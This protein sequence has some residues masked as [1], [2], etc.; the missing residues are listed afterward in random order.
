MTY[1]T[2][3]DGANLY[4]KDWG[5]G[6]PVVLMHGWPLTGDTF[7]RLG[8][9]LAENGYRVIIPD[10]RGFGRSDKTWNGNDYDTYADDVNAILDD[11]GIADKIAIIGFSMGGGEVARFQSRFPGRT[12]AAV[13][14]SSVVPHVAKSE[15]N[16]NGV[17]E[18]TLQEIT[19][20]LKDDHAG[21]FQGFFK[22]FLGLDEDENA[23]SDGVER[24]TFQQAM[25][26]S[27][28]NILQSANAWAT[29][30]FVPDLDHFDAP[31]LVIHGT[32]DK[33]VPIDATSRV[34]AEKLPDAQF[35]EY[36]GSPHAI[37]VTDQDRVID[38]VRGFL[39]NAMGER[40]AIPLSATETV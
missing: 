11:A 17:P 2:A 14:L 33:T 23:V 18:E 8:M 21:F 30:D 1:A 19:Q 4:Y 20:S 7:D 13:L 36:E 5:E 26:A 38:D 29:T 25:H 16:P 37:L 12:A 10:R 6:R 3:Q 34:V 31:T 39:D 9:E 15:D 22:E 35:I 40:S 32:K 28:H 24:D 27:I